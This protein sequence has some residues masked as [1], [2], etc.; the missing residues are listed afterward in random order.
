MK[1][2]CAKHSVDWNSVFTSGPDVIKTHYTEKF[3]S[4]E[5]VGKDNLE[6]RYK[7]RG[8]RN[9]NS[10]YNS[11]TFNWDDNGITVYQ[12]PLRGLNENKITPSKKVSYRSDI[13]EPSSKYA[14]VFVLSDDM[15]QK[16]KVTYEDAHDS[17]KVNGITQTGE[18]S[19]TY[20]RPPRDRPSLVLNVA[21]VDAARE[22][23]DLL[24]TMI[25]LA[26]KG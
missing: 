14:Y 24:K 5:L 19:G 4:L 1:E 22:V 12:V 8:F 20:S 15:S 23:A 10:V 18:D 26:K 11:K 9:A 21:T 6:L 2:L 16:V 3:V 25:E 17:Y 13:S 7:L